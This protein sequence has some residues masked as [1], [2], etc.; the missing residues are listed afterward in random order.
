[1]KK[2]LIM[3]LAMVSLM[4]VTQSIYA[5]STVVNIP[6]E[7]V[8]KNDDESKRPS[9]MG[10]TLYNGD[11]ILQN[12]TVTSDS[13]WQGEFKDVPHYDEA[14]NLMVYTVKSETIND[15]ETQYVQPVLGDITMSGFLEKTTPASNSIY[16]L[17]DSNLVI[18]KKGNT[19]YIWSL[20]QLN[21]VQL[22]KVLAQ[23]EATPELSGFNKNGYQ[24]AYGIGAYFE[25]KHQGDSKKIIFEKPNE[26]L[27]VNFEEPNLWSMFFVST[28]VETSPTKAQVI[29][30]YSNTTI[31]PVDEEPAPTPSPTPNPTPNPSPA[32]TTNPKPSSTANTETVAP[33]TSMISY[34]TLWALASGASL[35][36]TLSFIT[37]YKKKHH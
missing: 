21:D 18:A 25:V 19:L 8:W 7:V 31:E 12:I 1:M 28:M 24:V 9:Q 26:E 37:I 22:Q 3:L 20:K 13:N 36:A 6:I 10:V 11:T 2:I 29:N 14:G 35:I 32:P 27:Q 4:Y 15:Y 23:A 33:D 17:G 16:P 30:T 5:D 34:P